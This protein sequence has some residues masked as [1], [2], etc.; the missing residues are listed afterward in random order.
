M[1][2]ISRK[3]KETIVHMA[4]KSARLEANTACAWLNYQPK[5]PVSV[6]NCVSFEINGI[7]NR[8]LLQR[9]NY[10]RRR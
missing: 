9:R 10:F 1:Q 5:E 7:P 6:K 8:F 3:V 2:R 4:K